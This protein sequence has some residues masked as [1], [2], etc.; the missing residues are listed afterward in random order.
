MQLQPTKERL[1]KKIQDSQ[2]DTI[3][4]LSELIN[5]GYNMHE[6]DHA[7]QTHKN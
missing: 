1:T 5:T 2:E 4:V 7:E 3:T 6:E